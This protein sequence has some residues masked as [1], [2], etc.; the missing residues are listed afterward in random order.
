MNIKKIDITKYL[1][2]PYKDFGKDFSEVDCFGL[3]RL[4][5]KLEFHFYIP[6]FEYDNEWKSSAQNPIEDN[7]RAVCKKV[8]APARYGIVSFRLPGYFVEHHLGIVLYDFEQ[9]LHSPKDKPSC[10][11]KLSHPVWKRAVSSYYEVK[12]EEVI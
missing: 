9:F 8:I 4:F 10:V 11:D 2:I 5:F 7:Y 12:R 6:E 3:V 1:D